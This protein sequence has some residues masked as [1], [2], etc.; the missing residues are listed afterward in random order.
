MSGTWFHMLK[1]NKGI[2]REIE[3]TNIDLEPA[4]TK[5]IVLIIQN[6][7]LNVLY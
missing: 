3:I 7:Y 1:V 5:G 6:N 4:Y 2:R